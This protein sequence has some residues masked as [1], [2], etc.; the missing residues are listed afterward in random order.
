MSIK[1]KALALLMAALLNTQIVAC[2][3]QSIIE[4]ETISSANLLT[5]IQNQQPPLILDVRSQAEYDAGHIPGAINIEFRELPNHL[6]RLDRHKNSPVVIYCEKGIRAKVAQATL[7]KAGFQSILHLEGHL[8]AW[9]DN[10]LP[11]KKS[12][13]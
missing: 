4:V 13:S 5:E 6:D 3:A 2:D 1:N 10:S 12:T 8:S 9:R 11:I 7:S